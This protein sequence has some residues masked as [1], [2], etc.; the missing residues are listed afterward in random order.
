[1][2][3]V[4]EAL[5]LRERVDL[6]VLGNLEA[7]QAAVPALPEPGADVVTDGPMGDPLP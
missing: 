1:M 5:D 6:N 4:E 2:A 3:D 7:F